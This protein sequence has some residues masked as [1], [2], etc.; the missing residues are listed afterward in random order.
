VQIFAKKYEI[1]VFLSK[2]RFLT[3]NL[4]LRCHLKIGALGASASCP[5]DMT[6][7]FGIAFPY[8]GLDQNKACLF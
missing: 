6:P 5:T 4:Q 2:N 3:V 7:S 1:Y 8:T